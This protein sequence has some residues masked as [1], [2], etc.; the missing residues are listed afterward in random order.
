MG[1]SPHARRFCNLDGRIFVIGVGAQK[2]GTTWLYDYL[3]RHPQIAMSPIKELHY[4]DAVHRPDI[5]A[6]WSEDFR[7]ELRQLLHR[8]ASGQTAPLLQL[9]SLIDR[10]RMDSDAWAYLEYF[11]RLATYGR[12]VTGEITPSYSVIPETGFAAMRALVAGSGAAPRVIFIMREPV[13][14]FWSQCRMRAAVKG[15]TRS[16][17]QI[18][19]SA[20]QDPG[21][22]DRARY[23]WTVERLQKAFPA[24]E[25]LFLFYEQMFNDSVI[26]QV[27]GFLEIDFAPA[28][29]GQEI[30]KSPEAPLDAARQERIRGLLSPVYDFVDVR[31]GA[32][33]PASWRGGG[34]ARSSAARLA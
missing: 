32:S 34:V 29:F 20:Y 9:H 19:D 30:N 16:A 33:V 28:N 15:E 4:F 27:C 2:A 21:F 7:R 14:R 8:I 6:A 22:V 31:F 25:L 23:D 13:E 10:V 24:E 5:G 11:D 3:G 1:Q 26:R 17:E 18:C 12:R